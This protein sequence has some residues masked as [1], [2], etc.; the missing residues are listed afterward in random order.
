MTDK[1]TDKTTTALRDMVADQ[2]GRI[3]QQ[4][5]RIAAGLSDT[6]AVWRPD[7]EANS[8]AWLVWHLTRVQDDHVAF[9]AG[10]EQ[11]WTTGGWF[12]RFALP[13]PADAHGYG[14]SSADVAAVQTPMADLVAYQAEVDS[15]ST[16][17]AQ[18]LTAGSLTRV[19]DT[20]W[21]PPVTASVRLVSLIGDCLSHAGQAA[22]VRGLAERAGVR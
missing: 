21:D 18:A 13:F 10:H 2:F 4:V 14:H 19:V 6:A 5:Q 20:N 17:Y 9:L 15:M 11:V 12:E 8:I 22:Y 3:R 7:P 16:K 1:E